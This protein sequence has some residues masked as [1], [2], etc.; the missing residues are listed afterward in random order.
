MSLKLLKA[1]SI[2]IP[3]FLVGLLEV[4]RHAMFVEHGLMLVG[5]LVIVVT[6]LVGAFFLSTFVFGII[7]RIQGESQHRNQELTA[8][9]SV[10]VAVNESLNM[11]VIL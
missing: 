6:V 3:A 7:E 9:N 4:L 1:M 10:V 5:D 8:L 2:V 11:D